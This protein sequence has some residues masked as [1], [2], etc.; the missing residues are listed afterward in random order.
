[1]AGAPMQY[2]MKVTLDA[3]QVPAGARATKAELAGIGAEAATSTTKLQALINAQAGLGSPAANQNVREWSGALAMQGRSLDELRA[4]YNPLFAVINQYK[5]SL[6]EI[7][8]LHAQGVLSTNEMTAAIQRQRQATLGA[9]DVIK[10]RNKALDEQSGGSDANGRF[11]RQNLTYQ[12]FDIG[13]SS[14]LGMPL[15]MVAA[16]QLPQ[17]IQ[18]YAG[19]GGANAALKDLGTIAAGTARL[20]TPLTVGIGGLAAA[21]LTGLAAWNSYLSSTK[22]VETA[23]T[24]L[25]RAVAGSATQ[26]EAAA[27][28][29]ASAAGISISSARSMQAQF[30]STGRIGSEN[31]EKLI[32]ISKDFAATIGIDAGAAGDALSDMF[33]DPAKA[34]D[35]LY[36]QYGLINAAT[37]RQV[38]N[39]A[40]QNRVSEAQAV[41]LEALPN[42]LA[43]AAEATTALGRAWAFVT[44]SASNAYDAMGRAIDSVVSGPSDQERIANLQRI[45]KRPFVRDREGLQ[46]ELDGLLEQQRRNQAQAAEQQRAASEAALSRPAISIAESSAANSGTLQ[47]QALRNQ[48]ETLRSVNGIRG[49]DETQRGMIDT[50]IDAKTRALDALINRQQR[51]AELDRLDIQIQSERNP[52]IRAELEA[53][54]TRLQMADQEVSSAKITE[55]AARARNRVIGEAIAGSRMQAQD[56]STE[57]EIRT[58]L[59]S[60]V[61]AGTITS[62]EAQILLEQELQLRPLLA[63][64]AVAEG[65]AK[66]QLLSI[67]SQLRDGYAGMAEAQREASA[68]AIIRDQQNDLES[69]RAE[70]SLVGQSEA[71]RRRSLALLQAE[72]TIRRDG[73]S[74]NSASAAQ[75]RSNAAAMADMETSLDRATDAWDRYRSAGEGAI[76]TIFDGLASGDFDFGQIARDLFSDLSKTFLELSVKNPLKNAIFGT[77]Y[78]T[79]D[80]LL[81]PSTAI[82]S[83]L[84]SNVGAMTVNAATVMINGGLAS[85]LGGFSNLAGNAANSG[86]QA[87]TTLG[88]FLGAND[89]RT[90][91]YSGLGVGSVV[92]AGANR[93]T[94]SAVDL[95]QAYLGQ[96]ETGNTAS[97]NSFLSAGGVDINAAQT[98]WCAGFVN[99]AL[100]QIGVEGSGSLVANSF[101]NWGTRVD[102]S[103]VLR[104]DVLL[105]SRGLSS[106][107]TGGHVGLATGALRLSEGQLQLQ[108]LS[109][110]SSDSVA[111]SWVNAS[112]LQV[113]RA[114][115]A[116]SAL[117]RLSSSAGNTTAS[118]GGMGNGLQAATNGLG[119]FGSGLSQFGATMSKALGG[120]TGGM[121]VGGIFSSLS[122]AGWNMNILGSSSQVLGAVMR[123]SWGLWDDGGYTGAGGKYDPAGIVHRG[124]IV[125][126]QA[127]IARWGGVQAVEKLRLAPRG[128]ADGG[129]VGGSVGR[130]AMAA[131]NSNMPSRPAANFNISL[132]GARG[133]REIEEAARRGMESALRAYD[134]QLPDRMSEIEERRRWR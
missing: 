23:A 124:E 95:A 96:T 36:R 88:A 35:T 60:Q 72:Q 120:N 40:Q 73:I 28:G 9:I 20:I 50:A 80:D 112:E 123:G 103:Q 129:V 25:G 125:W 121:N 67:I 34:A 55:E 38:T 94:S 41:L 30:L 115:E 46:A 110:N 132:D 22:E 128:Y 6:T 104:G 83:A 1:M 33:A 53:R 131:A 52:L 82:G 71:I 102:A 4:K 44:T 39:L 15:G 65:D 106:T 134:A 68:A 2:S 7:R 49:I 91:G 89:N 8:T 42:R 31:F 93:M 76:D 48:I 47:Q 3:S 90:G 61:A 99:S 105:Q 101:Q 10:G 37:A 5:V 24:G 107:S 79:L 78:G 17:I 117:S 100:K 12:L 18:L 127:D 32:A 116:S 118:I 111:N 109:G 54:R 59:N 29:G 122:G 113:R 133:D 77:N 21:T 16:Q 64:A 84:G 63:A 56:L 43:S 45:V 57:V 51:T 19:Q 119:Q 98:A 74:A 26:M 86:F 126:S 69:L 66:Q 75:I 70:I 58:R 97:I 114:T 13:Q 130:A 14:A 108:M 27:A 11:R 85:G 92:T 62:S 87:N 81:N